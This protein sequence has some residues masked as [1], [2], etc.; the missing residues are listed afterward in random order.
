MLPSQ[1]ITTTENTTVN[2]EL[3]EVVNIFS[4]LLQMMVQDSLSMVRLLLITGVFTEEEE[5]KRSFI[6]LRDGIML[7][8]ISSRTGEE[9]T[10]LFLIREMILMILRL[11]LRNTFITLS[12]KKLKLTHQ[13]L[14]TLLNLTQE[15][16]TP[17]TLIK[18]LSKD[19][20]LL[21][22]LLLHSC[23]I[24]AEHFHN[25]LLFKFS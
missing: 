17:P 20:V 9:P 16:A 19:Q 10:S 2:L 15:V 25:S 23:E 1:E 7:R 21:T 4:K 12:N 22:L 18:T 5:E 6:S 24:E 3:S 11:P 14:P 8:L 13:R